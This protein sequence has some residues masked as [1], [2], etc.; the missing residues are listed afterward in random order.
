MT[1]WQA[2]VLVIAVMFIGIAANLFG[3]G[4]ILREIRLWRE[5]AKKP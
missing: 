1:Y 2:T 3:V 5:D 4:F